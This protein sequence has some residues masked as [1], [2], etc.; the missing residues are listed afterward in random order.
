MHNNKKTACDE[1]IKNP[2][3][4]LKI[5]ILTKETNCKYLLDNKYTF[6]MT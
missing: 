1:S 2:R 6:L 4:V 5:K 3:H